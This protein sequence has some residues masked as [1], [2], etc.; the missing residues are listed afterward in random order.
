MKYVIIGCV[1]VFAGLC[2]IFYWAFPPPRTKD[3]PGQGININMTQEEAEALGQYPALRLSDQQ[4]KEIRDYF[5]V[6]K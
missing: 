2:F 3:I 1:F 5:K 4:I 6:E